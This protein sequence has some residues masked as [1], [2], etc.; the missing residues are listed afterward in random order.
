MLPDVKV[1]QQ[2]KHRFKPVKSIQKHKKSQ[3][4]MVCED[5]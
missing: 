2:S 3:L 4:E 1:G 5:I